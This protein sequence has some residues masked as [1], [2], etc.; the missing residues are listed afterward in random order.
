[1]ITE[2]EKPVS[3]LTKLKYYKN[4]IVETSIIKGNKNFHVHI[5]NYTI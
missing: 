1:M 4:Y 5:Y 3:N 2:R